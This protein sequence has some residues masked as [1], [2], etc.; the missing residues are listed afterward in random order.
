MC[1]TKCK[2]TK[3][4]HKA[5]ARTEAQSKSPKQKH[6]T[7]ALSKK[8]KTKSQSK[9]IACKRTEQPGGT[10][11]QTSFYVLYQMAKRRNWTDFWRPLS[12]DV[13]LAAIESGY[14][15]CAVKYFYWAG[16]N[17]AKNSQKNPFVSPTP[18]SHATQP[19][20]QPRAIPKNK[21]TPFF[22]PPGA[23]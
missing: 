7:K 19:K 11:G 20:A 22:S 12:Y 13:P 15:G 10:G 3:Q 8:H 4:K 17:N 2:S 23:S 1:N 21:K 5:E 9:N 14:S 6:K 18:S 16:Q